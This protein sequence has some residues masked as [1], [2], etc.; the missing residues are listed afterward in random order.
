MLGSAWTG[1][2]FGILFYFVLGLTHI[3]IR[4]TLFH[5]A[6]R[7]PNTEETTLLKVQTVLAGLFGSAV[8][9]ALIFMVFDYATALELPLFIFAP[10]VAIVPLYEFMVL[11]WFRYFRSPSMQLSA[12]EET[13]SELSEIQ[14]WLEEIHATR[15]IPRFHMRIQQGD[16]L[17]ALAMG[18]VFRHLIVIGGGLL[19][20]MSALE[21]KGI[22]AH[23]I[24]H[25]ARKDIL[26]RLFPISVLGV[27]VYFVLFTHYIKPLFDEGSWFAGCTLMAI[28][29]SMSLAV[30]PGYVMRRAEFGAD[31]LAVELLGDREPLVKG[32]LKIAELTGQNL[33]Y[34]SGTHPP[35]RKRIAAI[36]ELPLP[37]DER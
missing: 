5:W 29:L 26:L 31:K 23:E 28:Y 35:M 10:L 6:C 21:I 16:L 30:I 27:T 4:P 18:G 3:Y 15:R 22:I 19:K 32:L 9:F 25:V 8:C 1:M 7:L 37:T 34:S 36:R 13:N 14:S 24:A 11:P 33:D 20:K 12:N 2:W 17:N